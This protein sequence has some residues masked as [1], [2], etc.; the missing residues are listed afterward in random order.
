MILEFLKNVFL[1]II[2]SNATSGLVGAV[3]GVWAT[4]FSKYK[5][6]KLYEK[7]TVLSIVEEL[8]VLKFSYENEFDNLYGDIN[9]DDF[10]RTRYV[11]SQD[12]MTVFTQNA[13]EIGLIK[14]EELRNL[15]IKSYMLIKNF[16]EDLKIYNEL[17]EQHYEI[18][19][20]KTN[21]YN[22][23]VLCEFSKRLRNKYYYLKKIVNNTIAK[24]N[25]IY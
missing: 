8:K 1:K 10:L 4:S 2:G 18:A 15:L 9:G 3:I 11:I 5:E 17:F 14:D 16:I 13:G 25:E 7:A 24:S 21:S 23:K 19:N 20:I 22:Y 12:Y 6:L